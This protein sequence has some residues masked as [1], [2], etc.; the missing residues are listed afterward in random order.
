MQ[1]RKQ[2]KFR[3]V[4]IF[5]AWA[6]MDLVGRVALAPHGAGAKGGV[7]AARSMTRRERIQWGI[8]AVLAVLLVV[9]VLWNVLQPGDQEPGVAVFD[10]ILRRKRGQ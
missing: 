7:M 6:I 4:R 3:G 10:E 5:P 8:L 2:A 1:A 9:I